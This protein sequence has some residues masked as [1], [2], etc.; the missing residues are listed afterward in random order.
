ML[1]C[2]GHAV[3]YSVPSSILHPSS[4]KT[5]ALL[6]LRPYAEIRPSRRCL[7]IHAM[8]NRDK[9]WIL[10]GLESGCAAVFR[11]DKGIGDKHG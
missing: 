1:F 8:R 2:D 5:P 11:V 3:L 6:K 4:L 9:I 10:A 7:G